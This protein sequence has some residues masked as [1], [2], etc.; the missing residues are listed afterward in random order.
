MGRREAS[1]REGAAEQS[2]Y[3]QKKGLAESKPYRSFYTNHSEEVLSHRRR[4]SRV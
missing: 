4:H 3:S 2:G 1:D